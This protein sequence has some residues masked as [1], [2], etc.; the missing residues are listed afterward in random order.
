MKLSNKYIIIVSLCFYFLLVRGEYSFAEEDTS[1]PYQSQ[2][3]QCIEENKNGDPRSIED[4][5]CLQSTDTAEIAYQIIMD[6]KYKEIDKKAQKEVENIENNC[7]TWYWENQTEDELTVPDKITAMY[8][9]HGKYW[10]DYNKPL[11]PDD[12]DGILATTIRCLGGK[13]PNAEASDFF[14]P[15][16][17]REMFEQQLDIFQDTSYDALKLC[18]E[19]VRQDERKKMMQESR[20]RYDW[21]GDLFQSVLWYLERIW[22]KWPSKTRDNYLYDI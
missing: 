3:D 11:N 7:E 4:F 14:S 15:S 19:E 18:K 10:Q 12:R 21:V 9:D 17:A 1:C 5:V 6:E 20:D 13:S 2:I 8:G 16:L 22:K